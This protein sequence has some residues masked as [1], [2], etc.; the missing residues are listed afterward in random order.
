MHK[1]LDFFP[2]LFFLLE[3]KHGAKALHYASDG[4]SVNMLIR[5]AAALAAFGLA[6]KQQ[7]LQ[8]I[9]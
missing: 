6:W 3:S 2:L 9:P 8:A 7:T 5:E 4:S 1:T